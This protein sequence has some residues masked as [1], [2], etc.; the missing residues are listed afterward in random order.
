M[1]KGM[2]LLSFLLIIT[3]SNAQD[4]I[5]TQS[6]EDIKSKVLE[7][8]V[9][10]IKYKKFDNPDG[11]NYSIEKK[12]VFK[13]AYQNGSEEIISEPKGDKKMYIWAPD[14][15][16][17]PPANNK[18]DK[19]IIL[20]ITDRRK[21]GDKV[22]NKKCTS[23]DIASTIVKTLAK[24]FPS[25]K[26]ELNNGHTETKDAIK[27]TVD[28][29]AYNAV[30]YP[31]LW[32]AFTKYEVTIQ[33]DNSI[34]KHILKEDKKFNMLGNPTGRKCLQYTFDQANKELVSFIEEQQ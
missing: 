1:K 2:A 7:V 8:G 11:P 31:S 5:I 34:V 33:K 30:Y 15:T 23:E 22:I 21:L 13:I 14:V 16:D 25:A 3:A 20:T 29:I 17:L 10:E 18:N 27:L 9:S 28:L 32:M 6:G 24:A 19:I 12:K 4:I 26:V